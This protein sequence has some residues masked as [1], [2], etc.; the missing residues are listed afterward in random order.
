[1]I[2]Y[3][4]KVRVALLNDIILSRDIFQRKYSTSYNALKAVINLEKEEKA[5]DKLNKKYFDKF[6]EISELK[7]N[8]SDDLKGLPLAVTEQYFFRK[9]KNLNAYIYIQY[10][11][12]QI[13][14]LRAIEIYQLLEDFFQQIYL[15]AVQIADHY[16]L[17]I[18][19]KPTQSTSEEETI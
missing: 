16:S 4:N 3:Q 11:D 9:S 12:I 6:T 7:D 2:G 1:M 15:L 14:N 19:M 8:L 10:K 5:K 18:K 17:D 13:T